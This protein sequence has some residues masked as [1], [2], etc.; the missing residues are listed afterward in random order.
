MEIV[1]P[2]RNDIESHSGAGAK[3]RR[4]AAPA[5]LLVLAACPPRDP[6]GE[7]CDVG[8]AQAMVVDDSVPVWP[9]TGAG[10]PVI[11]YVDRSQSM[12][13]F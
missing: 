1:I 8:R 13:G 5:L 11:L 3:P 10:R 4:W 9:T 12:R 2:G 6:C 7:V